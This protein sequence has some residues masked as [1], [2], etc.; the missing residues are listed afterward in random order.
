MSGIAYDLQSRVRG[1]TEA[2]TDA[3]HGESVPTLINP[4]GD[5]LISAGMPGISDLVR[6]RQSYTA[7]AAAALAPVAALPTT[8]AQVTLWNGELEN[9]KIYIIE[10]VGFFTAVSA[11]AATA[12]GVVVCMNIGKKSAPTSGITPKGLAGQVYR[13][14][15]IVATSASITD[16]KW[17]PYGTSI[18]GP[19][20]QIGL[21]GEYP[22]DGLYI[23]P[24]GHMFSIAVIA[25]TTTTITCRGFIRWHEV[26]LPV[27]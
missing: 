4:R 24:P 18:V 27:G 21:V 10:S 12:V 25:N 22:V 14:T 13:G 16:D 3:N 19:A 6:M 9:G 23:I 15:G 20:S 26:Q 11:A 17:F 2:V 1:K 7:I 5:L 8:T